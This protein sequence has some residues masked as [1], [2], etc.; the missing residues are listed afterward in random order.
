MLRNTMFRSASVFTRSARCLQTTPSSSSHASHTLKSNGHKTTTRALNEINKSESELEDERELNGSSLQGP[1]N[2]PLLKFDDELYAYL[3]KNTR[4]REI[5]FRLRTETAKYSPIGARMQIPVEQGQFMQ[6]VIEMIRARKILEIGVFTGYSSLAMLLAMDGD[7][8]VNN[9]SGTSSN[10]DGDDEAVFHACDIDEKAMAVAR[11]YWRE[12]KVDH[13]VREHI[14]D[15]KVSVEKIK[16]EFGDGYLD[17]CF[18]DADKRAYMGYYEQV[19]PMMRR[20]G[21]IIID[22]VLWYGRPVNKE[23]DKDA[24]TIAI[25]EFNEFIVNDKRVTHSLVPIGDGIS[26]CRKR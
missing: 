3:L 12:A 23:F 13:L 4:E 19:L 14:G 7:Y 10:R 16:E 5:L 20:G 24:K 11:K 21:L 9:N 18:I 17:L 2:S 15:A 6:L 1:I 22:N 25:K 26:I 8:G